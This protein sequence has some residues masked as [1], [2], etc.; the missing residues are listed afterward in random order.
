VRVD[1]QVHGF[2][3]REWASWYK[4]LKFMQGLP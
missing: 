3:Y 4:L 2:S 1:K